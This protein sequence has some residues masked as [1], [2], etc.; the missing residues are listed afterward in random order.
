MIDEGV[1]VL[2]KR[3]RDNRGKKAIVP[4]RLFLGSESPEE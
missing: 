3:Q 4:F 2:N 1:G